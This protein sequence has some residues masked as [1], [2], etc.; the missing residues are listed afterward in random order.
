MTVA[1]WESFRAAEHFTMSSARLVDRC[2]FAHIFQNGTA[3]RV[4]SAVS[5]YRNL[6]GGYGNG[7][8]PDLRGHAS[9][10]VS[11]ATALL[12]LDELGPI[13]GDTT[14]GIC[15]YLTG[16]TTPDGGVPAVTPA[17]RH[18]PAAPW[19]RNR[20]DFTSDLATTARIAGY[21]HK[22]TV[23]HPWRDTATAYCWRHID[24]LHWTD[25]R[26]AI[27]VCTFLDHVPDRERARRALARLTPM[28]RAAI[29]TEPT[30][31]GPRHTHTPLD[32]APEP[33]H[34]ARNA[35]T[36]TEIARSL[37]NLE[38]LQRSDGAWEALEHH[39]HPTATTEHEGMRTVQSLLVLRAYG[40]IGLRLPNPRRDA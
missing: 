14:T 23:S 38:A 32:L 40:R 22:H 9:Q 13:P 30:T 4:R 26:E 39:W 16:V 17:V 28:I 34:I 21:L 18:T 29:D 19:W 27:G 7:L 35:F 25:P 3:D 37:D 1:T 20:T 5:A 10:P 6:D 15:R 24:A 36:D 8:H 2:R 11:T 12:Y 33:G 31:F